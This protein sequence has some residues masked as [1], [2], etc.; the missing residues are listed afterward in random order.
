MK[1]FFFSILFN[2]LFDLQF[3]LFAIQLAPSDKGIGDIW[4]ETHTVA[5][6]SDLKSG[7]FLRGEA[8]Y[9]RINIVFGINGID[10]TGTDA[11]DPTDK[12]KCLKNEKIEKLIS[13]FWIPTFTYN[14]L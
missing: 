10:R 12:G 9:E 4:P 7:I 11:F 2:Y 13:V 5:V 6:V 1:L 3:G 14:R 8:R